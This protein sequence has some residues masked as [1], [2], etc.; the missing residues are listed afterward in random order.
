MGRGSAYSLH[1]LEARKRRVRRPAEAGWPRRILWGFWQS[2]AAL[3]RPA[4]FLALAGLAVFCVFDG[5]GHLG[6]RTGAADRSERVRE[7]FASVSPSASAAASRW[8]HELDIAMRPRAGEPPDSALAMSLLTALEDIVGRE[9]FSSLAW[10]E[11]RGRST[12]EAEAILRA[13]PV[14]VRRRELES[15]WIGRVGV[16]GAP[17]RPDA[18]IWLAPET[19][20][21]RLQRAARLYD[22]VQSSQSMFFA[23]HEDGALNLALLPGLA[24]QSGELWIY[25]DHA[26]AQIHCARAEA[27][28]CALARMGSETGAGQGARLMRA[29]LMSGHFTETLRQSLEE[30]DLQILQAL[31]S[32]TGAVARHTSNIDAI[33]LMALLETPQDVVGLRRLSEEAGPRT[34]ALAHFLGRNAL[35]LENGIGETGSPTQDARNRFILAGVF[36]FLA[37]GLVAAA[38]ASAVSVRLTGKAG[39]GQRIDLRMRELL[40]GRKA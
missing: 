28:E 19:A 31:A 8:R 35:A 36:G 40:L 1:R 13:L 22:A 25:S 10:A 16:A 9:R 7:A 20:R 29:A 2:A 14:W 18:A 30:A 24:T 26:A 11:M 33:R 5:L 34:L 38:V 4:A 39:L 23:G 21:V 27:L 15:A 32:E 37:F 3:A 12:E 17:Y 6:P